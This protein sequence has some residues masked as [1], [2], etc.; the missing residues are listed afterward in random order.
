MLNAVAES[1]SFHHAKIY[2]GR[3][4]SGSGSSGG[5]DSKLSFW[6]RLSPLLEMTADKGPTDNVSIQIAR[7]F[8]FVYYRR[9]ELDMMLVEEFTNS[10]LKPLSSSSGGKDSEVPPLPPPPPPPPSDV[11]LWLLVGDLD[12]GKCWC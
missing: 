3:S 9:F 11:Q 4:T 12:L 2:I 8:R 1:G 7:S 6:L 5:S 10:H